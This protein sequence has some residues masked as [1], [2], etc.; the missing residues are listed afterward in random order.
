MDLLQ[1]KISQS[2]WKL[3]FLLRTNKEFKIQLNALI[4]DVTC[5]NL[6]FKKNKKYYSL[7]S[8]V[9]PDTSLHIRLL[10]TKQTE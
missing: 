7:T 4:L 1:E 5:F 6:M 8:N 10:V 3:F 2:H 9:L